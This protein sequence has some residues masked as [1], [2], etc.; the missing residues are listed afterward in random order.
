MVII[1]PWPIFRGQRT[2]SDARACIAE[3]RCENGE[4][5]EARGYVVWANEHA[6]SKRVGDVQEEKIT[7]VSS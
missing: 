2:Q 5:R 1:Q 4:R 7:S 6:E 3:L